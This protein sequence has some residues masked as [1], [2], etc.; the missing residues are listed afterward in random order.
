MSAHTVWIALLGER[1]ETARRALDALEADGERAHEVMGETHAELAACRAELERKREER[2]GAPIVCEVANAGPHAASVHVTLPLAVG[3]GVTPRTIGPHEEERDQWGARM[4][5]RL[6]ECQH[7]EAR[8]QW[9]ARMRVLEH[10]RAAA[11]EAARVAREERDAALA[12]V[13]ALLARA[14]VSRP[15]PEPE[16]EPCVRCGTTCGLDLA[17][18]CYVCVRHD[19]ERERGGA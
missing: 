16:P 14:R 2:E 18:L 9:L 8:I 19:R 12:R 11:V 6:L 7:E 5:V 1:L 13:D 17:G 10:E 3:R 4:R 15:K